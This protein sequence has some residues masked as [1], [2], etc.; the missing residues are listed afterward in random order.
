[1]RAMGY[2]QI[3]AWI[4]ADLRSVLLRRAAD[5]QKTLSEVVSEALQRDVDLEKTRR[6]M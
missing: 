4:K 1:M 3:H 2:Q 6:G 5:E